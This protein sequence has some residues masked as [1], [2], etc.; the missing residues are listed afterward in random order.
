MPP[1]LVR[2]A[3]AGDR[4]AW[5]GDDRERPLDERGQG[6]ARELVS[7]LA[8]FAV[9]AIYASPA[10]RCRETVEPLAAAR[11]LQVVVREELGEDRQWDD[12]GSLLHELAPLDVVVCGHGGLEQAALHDPP[13]WRKGAA[14]VLDE[15]LRIVEKITI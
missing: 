11:G 9:D 4:E 5:D 6:Q 8:P 7:R 12:G 14:F 3:S 1:I 2:H 10:L 15:K 13:K